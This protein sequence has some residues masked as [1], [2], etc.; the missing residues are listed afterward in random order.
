MAPMGATEQEF[1]S[2]PQQANL[3][4]GETLRQ[5]RLHYGLEIADVE[6][7]LRIR[8]MYLHALEE[9]RTDELPGRVYAIGFVRAYAEYLGLDGADMVHLLKTQ[10]SESANKQEFHFPAAASESKMPQIYVLGGSF[11]ALMIVLSGLMFIDGKKPEP[12]E[13]PAVAE[14]QIPKE[15]ITGRAPLES[16]MY[17][18][19]ETA[20]GVEGAAAFI[21]PESRILLNVL[22]DSW[23]EIRGTNG[24]AILSR[25]LK[26]GDRFLVPNEEGLLLSTGNAGGFSLRVDDQPVPK[27]G[28]TGAILRAVKLDPDA[29]L[30]TMREAQ[31]TGEEFIDDE[32]AAIP[33]ATIKKP[34]KEPVRKNPVIVRTPRDRER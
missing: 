25:I 29:L 28:I 11:F 33:A 7:A 15:M 34:A 18:A 4:V 8:A 26:K 22:D 2:S 23:V 3:P 12:N 10:S 14:V 27:L 19:I 13:I 31:A 21:K 32:A 16:A 17:A 30:Q 24:K 5:A 9:G 6:A 1:R 20:V